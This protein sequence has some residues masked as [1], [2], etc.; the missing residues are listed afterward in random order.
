[1]SVVF[2]LRFTDSHPVV[3]GS[4][5]VTATPDVLPTA[6]LETEVVEPGHP[7]PLTQ[8]WRMAGSESLDLE[9][10]EATPVFGEFALDL[11]VTDLDHADPGDVLSGPGSPVLLSLRDSGAADT[12]LVHAEVRTTGQAQVLA[13]QVSR[14]AGPRRIGVWLSGTD[15]V[16]A[17]DGRT[18]VRRRVARSVPDTRGVVRLGR[19]DD[20]DGQAATLPLAGARLAD[21]LSTAQEEELVRAAAAGLGEIDSL[22][23][24]GA[25]GSL[26][27]AT[28]PERRSGRARW[29]TF[30]HG[31]V[32]WSAETGAHA[33]RGDIATAHEQRGGAT[34][35][36]GLP[37]SP[38]LGLDALLEQLGV[39]RRP[40]MSSGVTS[41]DMVQ[42][43]TTLAEDALVVQVPQPV[44]V[45]PTPEP[46]PRLVTDWD[47]IRVDALRDG[48][49]LAEVW[50]RAGPVGLSPGLERLSRRLPDVAERIGGTHRGSVLDTLSRQLAS[51]E[52][53]LLEAG[54][55]EPHAY[56]EHSSLARAIE[57]LSPSDPATAALVVEAEP[58]LA[59]LFEEVNSLGV[60]ARITA[61]GIGYL[62]LGT[63]AQLFQHG[64]VVSSA[65]AGPIVL[66]DEILA[67]WLLHG[68]S[69]GCL[70]MP[71]GSQVEVTG[72]AHATFGGGRIYH[73]P[74]TGAHE[75]H[76]AI[77]ARY[78]TGDTSRQLGFPTTDEH[79]VPGH[80]TARMSAFEHGLI[81]WTP[82]HGAVVLR[83][84]FHRHWVSQGGMSRYGL[85]RGEVQQVHEAG[86][87]LRWQEFERGV[88]GWTEAVGFFDQLQVRISRVATGRIDDGYEPGFAGIP[89]KDTRAELFV[90]AWVW[91]DGTQV[92]QW[93][94]HV[95]G[96]ALD[97][98]DWTVPAFALRPG[99]TV[100]IRIEAWDHDELSGDDHLADLDVTHT[101][102]GEFWGY[103]RQ[104]GNHLEQP[105]TWNDPSNAGPEAVTFDYTLTP[106]FATDIAQMRRDHFW[107]FRNLGRPSLP[108]SMYRQTFVDIDGA[109]VNYATDP[110]DS[111][112][113]ESVYEDVG[114]GGNCFG[115]SISALD[116]FHRLGS[117][118]QPLSQLSSDRHDDPVW[119]II[120]RG[121]GAQLA[122]SVVLWKIGARLSGNLLDPRKVWARVK[123]S[124][125]AGFPV[126]LSLRGQD[127][128]H[129]VLVHA[130]EATAGG[131]HRMYLADSNLPFG[132]GEE[133]R[134][135][136]RIDIARD[137]S[138]VVHRGSQTYTGYSG[139]PWRSGTVPEIHMMEVP[140]GLLGDPL[141]TPV[142]DLGIA[143]ASLIGGLITGS[144]VDIEQ[145][146]SSGRT[147]RGD[148]RDRLVADLRH[149]A[150]LTSSAV[151]AGLAPAIVE[152]LTVADPVLESAVQVKSLQ[153]SMHLARTAA[154]F[155]AGASDSTTTLTQAM[156][157]LPGARVASESWGPITDVG[158]Y[159]DLIESQIETQELVAGPSYSFLGA[160][161]DAAF[162][163][164]DD[165]RDDHPGLVAFRGPVPAD[166]TVTLRGRGTRYRHHLASRTGLI[167]LSA[168]LARGATDSVHV[169][170]L[171]GVRPGV[172]LVS[173][174]AA[175]VAEVSF[176]STSVA[177]ALGWTVPL[178]A[179]SGQQA[180]VRWLAGRPGLMV[181]HATAVPAAPV[182]WGTGI[183]QVYRCPAAAAGEQLR[184]LPHD[185]AS[186]RGAIRVERLSVLGDLVDQT[187]LDPQ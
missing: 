127:G 118:A 59:G 174:G 149:D 104:A 19:A 108:W 26:G 49:G 24:S 110:L 161:P 158:H 162:V 123:V 42:R 131:A 117:A 120:N 63:R 147:L 51:G 187:V 173:A 35:R 125:D 138:Y 68:A 107:R 175:K 74:T 144:A 140:Y 176:R 103:S 14:D 12:L 85:P 27:A 47:T 179:G 113:Y 148:Q 186:P 109:G 139:P 171:S 95:A 114:F 23:E 88:V 81:A 53:S 122:A 40:G 90:K 130:C 69:H 93:H 102:S 29:R 145:V 70:G 16:L 99:T 82:D 66:F 101:L 39:R 177:G 135:R 111:W 46:D 65:G 4:W 169:Q 165:D 184:L 141:R 170:Q 31:T 5:P 98:P 34:G 71:R 52:L 142:W 112:Y 10:A 163:G 137:G 48:P 84:P 119:R 15:V 44:I 61:G 28:G 25:A 172:A 79:P 92:G 150:L 182:R 152:P 30:Q 2:A 64:I 67:H 133:D 89:R 160:L 13:G 83:A 143:L 178:G 136:S 1:M 73:S 58:D 91:V 33:V 11:V 54:L 126:M 3:E 128:G 121:Q 45:T 134:A 183:S 32:Y 181:R 180:T 80:A 105:S 57:A 6:P 132:R 50:G 41:W 22:V 86:V 97:L 167:S 166:L 185:P 55:V 155:T 17:V 94:S 106:P 115:F 154:L 62:V 124:T 38:E 76:G 168:D 60:E 36:L 37:T 146:E 9:P 96:P 43:L 78:L 20:Q 159:A 72:G 87:T 129:T 116:A 157:S 153:T 77:L 164:I 75:V 156:E 56:V 7:E 18:L 151:T 8:V 100:R 21:Q